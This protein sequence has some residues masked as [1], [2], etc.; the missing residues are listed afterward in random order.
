MTPGADP[1]PAVLAAAESL[2][3]E[4]DGGLHTD[5][6]GHVLRRLTAVGT[7]RLESHDATKSL[8]AVYTPYDIAAEVVD[9]VAPQPGEKVF[10]PAV[11]G[12]VFLLA[13]AERLH[14]L[15]AP[16]GSITGSLFG[17]D[18]DPTSVA[19]TKVVLQL[20]AEWRAGEA[21][22]FDGVEV[23]DGLLTSPG[24]RVDVVVGNPPFL[25]QLKS[26]TSREPE[27]AG[28][29]RVR[30][31]DAAQ[32]YVDDSALF[33]LQ[34]ARLVSPRGRVAL[35]GPISNLAATSTE[36]LRAIIDDELPL[37]ALWLGGR[38]VFPGVGVDAVAVVLGPGGDAVEVIDRETCES[39]RVR[40]VGPQWQELLADYAGVPAIELDAPS[41]VA[42]LAEVTAD[43]RDAYY[44]LADRVT[45]LDEPGARDVL[46][47]GLVD[48]LHDR[49]GST[50]VRFA[51]QRF[52]RL[53][54]TFDDDVDSAAARWCA[55][56]SVPK[57]LVATQTKVVECVVDEAGAALPSTPLIVVAPHDV[58][59]L[60]KLAAA[61]SSP[62]L[63]AWAH[64]EAGGTGL[65]GGTF[66]LRAAQLSGA[67]LPSRDEPWAEAAAL[68]RRMHR[69]GTVSGPTLDEF[70]ELGALM[71]EAYG[72]E[73]S[74]AQELLAWW[75]DLLPQ[76]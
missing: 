18:L 37:S 10:D 39:I 35:L 72:I 12:G 40:R 27:R 3:R 52:E 11:G 38:G 45:A 6:D 56:R 54:V 14:S 62:V 17:L 66:R 63:S 9:L 75:L 19:T 59:D 33:L 61:F 24:A 51:K 29:L 55:R 58:G 74:A 47:V 76:R 71:N 31:G 68:A 4:L 60:W 65:G 50:T 22:A 15:G 5:D 69:R 30:F 48:P 43:F 73:G 7:A 64:R 1:P 42:T 8:G 49:T 28:A 34:G 44:W 57:L 26:S 41:R 70:S 53:R 36:A 16:L 32:P 23:G 21:A 67:P 46:T 20:W 25:G 13:T 2:R